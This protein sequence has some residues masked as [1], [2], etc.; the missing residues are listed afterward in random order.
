[1]NSDHHG[2]LE[3]AANVIDEELHDLDPLRRRGR[4]RLHAMRKRCARTEQHDFAYA[5]RGYLRKD[6]P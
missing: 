3:Y 1:M 5:P 2:L 6:T 4:V